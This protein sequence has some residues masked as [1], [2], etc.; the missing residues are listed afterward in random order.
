MPQGIGWKKFDQ[1]GKTIGH[2][3]RCCTSLFA[4]G[5]AVVMD[6]RF[7]VLDVL[8]RLKERGVYALIMVKNVD[9]GPK[10]SLAM[11]SKKKWK[12]NLL[13]PLDVFQ[14]QKTGKSSTFGRSRNRI[15]CLC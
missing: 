9:H 12:T 2:V 11:T 8:P 4:R 13:E 10:A 15:T 5:K 3:L 14:D 7:A 6:S 1:Y